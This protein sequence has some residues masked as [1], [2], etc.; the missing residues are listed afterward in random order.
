MAFNGYLIKL[1]GSGGTELPMKFMSIESYKSTPNQRMESKAA[2]SVT[3][4]LN[5]TTVSHVATKIEF[6]TPYMTN[7]DR[8]QLNDLLAA[9]WIVPLERKIKIYFYDDENDSYREATCY[10]PDV[11]YTIDHIDLN[12]NLVYYKPVRYAFIEY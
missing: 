5:R 9:N 4:V 10:M 6:E 3:G 1:G 8:K 2:R 12:T 7:L 11:Q